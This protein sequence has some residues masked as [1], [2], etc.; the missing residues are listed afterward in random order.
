MD[1]RLKQFQ[2]S[3]TASLL[4]LSDLFEPPLP[5][6]FH[7]FN[8]SQALLKTLGEITQESFAIATPPLAPS[9]TPSASFAPVRPK[10]PLIPPVAKKALT[11]DQ[12]LLQALFNLRDQKN[13]S[14]KTLSR[15]TQ[16]IRALKD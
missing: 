15:Y 13:S 10:A 11:N 14:K 12:A 7:D 8:Q 1:P 3:S 16:I 6:L 9:S 4:A 5:E 2:E